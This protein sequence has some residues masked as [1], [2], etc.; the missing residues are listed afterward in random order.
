MTHRRRAQ[1]P[2]APTFRATPTQLAVAKL[3][4]VVSL[5]PNTGDGLPV[6]VAEA[7]RI[8]V[9]ED[10]VVRLSGYSRDH[11]QQLAAAGWALP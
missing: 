7:M 11:V 3:R 2:A 6:A 8:G 4:A 5:A 1:H 10:D 9:P